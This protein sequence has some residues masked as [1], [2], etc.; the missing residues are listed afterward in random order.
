VRSNSWS[1]VLYWLLNGVAGAVGKGPRSDAA[2]HRAV[3]LLV[4]LTSDGSQVAHAAYDVDTGGDGV[5]A[6]GGTV[7]SAG[8]GLDD[9][10]WVI[11]GTLG[12]CFAEM[13]EEMKLRLGGE[14]SP[15]YLAAL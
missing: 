6:G 8:T 7:T 1:T 4:E 9:R 12:N 3:P 11:P 10:G 15:Q 13:A 2:A 5:G 14:E